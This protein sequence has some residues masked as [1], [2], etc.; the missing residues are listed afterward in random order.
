MHIIALGLNYKTAPVEVREV[1]AVQPGEIPGALDR[2]DAL[3]IAE[4]VLLSTCNRTEIYAVTEDIPQ[5]IEVLTGYLTEIGRAEPGKLQPHLYQ[6]HDLDAVDHLFR[7][8]AGLDSMVLGETQIL[9][10]VRDAYQFAIQSQSIGTVLHQLF[11]QAIATGKRGQSETLIG[12]NAVSV[13][14]A[15]VE[16]AK[17]VYRTLQGRSALAIGAG[18]TGKLTVKHLQASGVEDVVIANRTLLRAQALAAKIDG[19]PI[20]MADVGHALR[21]VDVV[22]SA[23]GSQGFVLNRPT[24]AEALR[25]RRGRPIFLFDIAVPRDIDPEIGKLDGVFLYDIDDLQAVVAANLQERAG[26]ARKVERI[27][28]DEVDKFRKWFG[29]REVVPTIRMLREKM[30]RI[31][32]GEVA[33][34]LARLPDLDKRQKAIIEAMTVTMMNKMLNDPTQRLKGLAGEGDAKT[35][36]DAVAKLFD[37][38]ADEKQAAPKPKPSN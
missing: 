27:V 4:G 25:H 21:E 16:L 32:Q 33:R 7:V 18:E 13:S 15:A 22:I 26:E 2:L 5:A 35:A 28:A 10:Q 30:E 37:L 19:R 14:Y 24:V 12:Q 38:P 6:F 11:N 20:P 23:T 36:I 9:G 8:A 34:T 29:A 1:L 17:K 31:R 3:P